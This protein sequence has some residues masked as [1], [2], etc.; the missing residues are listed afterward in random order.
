MLTYVRLNGP[1]R[2]LVTLFFCHDSNRRRSRVNGVSQHGVSRVRTHTLEDQA[3][4]N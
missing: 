3:S 4:T 1:R 2:G